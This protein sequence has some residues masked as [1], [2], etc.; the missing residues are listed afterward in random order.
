MKKILLAGAAALFIVPAVAADLPTK[1]AIV[2]PVVTVYNWTGFYFGGNVGWGWGN[3]SDTSY[4]YNAS[5]VT[6][7]YYNGLYED[8]SSFSNSRFIGG[9]QIG[10]RYEF[11]QHFVIGAEAN[12]DWNGGSS[13]TF[14]NLT[15]SNIHETS[16]S[17]VGGQVVGIAGY[18]LGDFLP[19]IKGGWAWSSQN[20]TRTQLYGKTGG[21]APQS[22]TNQTTFQEQA[23][24][25]RN[26][27]TIG[28]GLSYHIWNNWE[29][30]GQY[31]YT[32]YGTANIVFLQSQRLTQSS[33]NANAITAGVNLKF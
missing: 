4:V 27:W 1:K 5:P 13:E 31:M 21:L 7:T 8:S 12:L 16:S 20:V 33:V 11:P 22:P 32:K 29:V 10:Y 9:G 25:S 18:A 15:G 24:V 19:Y 6:K 14:S 2:L 30:F 23:S 3:T 17:G 28:A 26:G